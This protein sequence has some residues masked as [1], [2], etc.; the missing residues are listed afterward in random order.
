M[1][2]PHRRERDE[3]EIQITQQIEGTADV[4][5]HDELVMTA[6]GK[7][8]FDPAL[9]GTRQTEVAVDDRARG[10]H[11]RDCTDPD[12]DEVTDP[13]VTREETVVE[14]EEG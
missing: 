1:Q 9:S 12:V 10:I 7:T 8:G 2:L 11:G 6:G 3:E 14:Q 13:C 5:D 4:A